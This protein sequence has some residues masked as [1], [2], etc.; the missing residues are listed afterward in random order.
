[1][2]SMRL[3][4]LFRRLPQVDGI[5]CGARQRRSGNRRRGNQRA[6]HPGA[7]A[8]GVRRRAFRASGGLAARLGKG[9]GDGAVAR[10]HRRTDLDLMA[11][12]AGSETIERRYQRVAKHGIVLASAR[13]V[14]ALYDQPADG[15][16]ALQSTCPAKPSRYSTGRLK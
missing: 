6:Q 11:A 13:E 12:V 7:G 1:M 3:R 8:G 4:R 9:R 16:I 2:I 5:G 14:Q 15:A 10:V